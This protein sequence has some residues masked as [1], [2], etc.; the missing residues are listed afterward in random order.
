MLEGGPDK[1]KEKSFLLRESVF[2]QSTRNPKSNALGRW[3]KRLKI[4]RILASEQF[5]IVSYSGKTMKGRTKD[6]RPPA[7]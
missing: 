1:E 6:E 7:K 4:Y 3:K 2:H 5:G